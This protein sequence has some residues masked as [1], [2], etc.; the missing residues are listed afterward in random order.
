MSALFLYPL[1]CP[2]ILF[3]YNSSFV[4]QSGG[5]LCLIKSPVQK[6]KGKAGNRRTTASRTP[7]MV[8]NGPSTPTHRSNHPENCQGT[9]LCF[10]FFPVVLSFLFSCLPYP[11]L[12]PPYFLA[13]L[14]SV[15]A[16]PPSFLSL[17]FPSLSHTLKLCTLS[18]IVCP[19]TSSSHC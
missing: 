11:S 7:T 5:F 10:L 16:M 2:G 3:H 19:C 13:P 6:R 14:F 12:S 9:A 15:L 1:L 18:S 8:S 4:C 17:G